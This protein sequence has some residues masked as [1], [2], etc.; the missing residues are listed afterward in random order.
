MFGIILFSIR[1]TQ[2]LRPSDLPEEELFV[3]II[4]LI[5]LSEGSLLA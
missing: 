1:T 2:K 5:E 3:L 4:L